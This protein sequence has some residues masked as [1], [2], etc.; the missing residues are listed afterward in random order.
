MLNHVYRLIVAAK[1]EQESAIAQICIIGGG[2]AGFFAIQ[3]AEQH[4]DA[5]V[6]ILEGAKPLAKVRIS[7]GGRCNVTTAVQEPRELITTIHAVKNYAGR[8]GVLA[9][10]KPWFGLLSTTLN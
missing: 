6:L 8:F 9:H 1:E 2:A 10:A 5:K 7:G 4:P 3:A